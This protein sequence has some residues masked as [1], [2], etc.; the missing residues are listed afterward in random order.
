MLLRSVLSA[1]FALHF[2]S[3]A[4]FAAEVVVLNDSTVGGTPSTVANV[5][6]SGESAASWLAATGGRRS[7]VT[8]GEK[9]AHRGTRT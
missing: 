5:F 6:V 2:A 4:S 9:P 1:V 8:H 3:P 7:P